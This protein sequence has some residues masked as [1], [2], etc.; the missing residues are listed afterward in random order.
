M[1]TPQFISEETPPKKNQTPLIIAVI[2]II[3]CC[4]CLVIVGYYGYNT[5]RS[6]QTEIQPL[7]EATP[8]YQSDPVEDFEDG[9]PDVDADM[10]DAPTGGLGNDILRNDT[11][12]Y[13]GFV[14]IGMGC[15][16]PVGADSTIEVLQEPSGGVW[17]EKWTVACASGDSYPFEVE[18]IVDDTGATFNITALP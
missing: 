18:F 17:L 13:I 12:Q 3:L 11:W 4:F 14:A 7:E 10:G 6:T 16:E 2:A 15:D 5:I 1:E 8:E 9:V